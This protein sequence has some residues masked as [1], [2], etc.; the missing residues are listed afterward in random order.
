MLTDDELLVMDATIKASAM[1]RTE[2]QREYVEVSLRLYQLSMMQA[3]A[4]GPSISEMQ[5]LLHNARTDYSQCLRAWDDP[6]FPRR[7]AFATR[8][9]LQESIDQITKV[10]KETGWT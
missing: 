8:E 5:R 7:V 6:T 3:E 2:L 9:S 10:L 4:R 1:T